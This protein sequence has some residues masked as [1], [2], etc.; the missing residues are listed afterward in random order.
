MSHSDDI[1]RVADAIRVDLADGQW[2][3]A[4][5]LGDWAP[6]ATVG[7]A[8]NRLLEQEVIEQDMRRRTYRLVPQHA[9][10]LS[11]GEEGNG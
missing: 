9:R 6:A 4:V 3:H 7:D 1:A 2:H 8:L 5:G 10:Q 11:P